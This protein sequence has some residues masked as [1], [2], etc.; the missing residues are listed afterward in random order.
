MKVFGFFVCLVFFNVPRDSNSLVVLFVGVLGP[1]LCSS[2]GS[3]VLV[4]LLG[5]VLVYSPWL[6]LG[7]W[8]MLL[9]GVLGPG[10]CSL[11]ESWILVEL[12]SVVLGPSTA[13]TRW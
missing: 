6:G 1:G 4:A 2:V 12:L 3:W 13:T 5:G 8:F 9:A 7:S 10:L 11:V